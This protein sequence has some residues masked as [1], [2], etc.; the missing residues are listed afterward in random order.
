MDLPAREQ[1]LREA[2]GQAALLDEFERFF[3]P[4]PALPGGGDPDHARQLVHHHPQIAGF[5]PYDMA[6]DAVEAAAMRE[7]VALRRE[8][9]ED[10]RELGLSGVAAHARD[11]RQL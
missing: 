10:S 4:D 9:R 6:L 8:A 2:V 3:A 1:G 5:D 11:G 7:M